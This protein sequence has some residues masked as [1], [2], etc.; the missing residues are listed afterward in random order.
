MASL[1]ILNNILTHLEI[2]NMVKYFTHDHLVQNI[3]WKWLLESQLEIKKQL[4]I[5]QKI[6]WSTET[7][8]LLIQLHYIF[9]RM[10]K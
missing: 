3:I 8:N 4:H 7:K 6:Y 1:Y 5:M 10:E 9:L 2:E